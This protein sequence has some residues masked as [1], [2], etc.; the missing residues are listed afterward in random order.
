MKEGWSRPILIVLDQLKKLKELLFVYKDSPRIPK[1]ESIK[2]SL[3]SPKSSVYIFPPYSFDSLQI[4]QYFYLHAML[5]KLAHRLEELTGTPSQPAATD[6]PEWSRY[7]YPYSSWLARFL[8]LLLPLDVSGLPSLPL[9]AWCS[10]RFPTAL[11]LQYHCNKTTKSFKINF[12]Q[13]ME[14]VESKIIS[15]IS[16]LST[17]VV[18]PTDRF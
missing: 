9:C 18:F 8:C 10:V 13:I 12:Y 17:K 2:G 1:I 6:H 11:W 5:S 16:S 4:L 14:K 7:T 15:K 3:L